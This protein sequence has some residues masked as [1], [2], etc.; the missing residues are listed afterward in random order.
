MKYSYGPVPSRRLGSSLGIDIVPFKKCSFD[1]IYCQLGRTSTKTVQRE[2]YFPISE[3]LDDIEQAL[4]TD[5]SIDYITFSGSGEPT[6]N[7]DLG[8]LISMVKESTD[9]PV[10][11]ITNGS[12]LWKR[13][14]QEDLLQADL[15]LPSLDTGSE[16]LFQ[17][18]NRPH[19]R[20]RLK[21]TVDGLV[22]FRSKFTGQMWL[23]I[24]LL[25]GVNAIQEEIEKIAA[26]VGRI[27]PDRVQLNTAVRPPAEPFVVPLSEERMERF[28][29]L[30]PCPTEIIAQY[31]RHFEE[32]VRSAVS[33]RIKELLKRRPCTLDDMSSALGVHRNELVKHL[34]G[35]QKE[36]IVRRSQH[37]GHVYFS[38]RDDSVGSSTSTS[39]SEQRKVRENE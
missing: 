35:L 20:L 39:I 38:I 27:R 34:E 24:F 10:A 2:S 4:N 6:L 19:S 28:V 5:V 26:A 17:Y 23:E 15:I 3:I 13:E 36:D 18:I 12:L 33:P 22:D 25:G 37:D 32:R 30:F 11:V 21:K 29:D 14:V 8:R 16:P 31:D 9:I 1:C 7:K